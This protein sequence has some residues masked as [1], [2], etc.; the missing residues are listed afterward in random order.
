[1]KKAKKATKKET[2]GLRLDLGCGQGCRAGY[3]GVDI[4]KLPGVKYVVD[5]TKFPWPWKDGSVAEIYAQQF[6]EH[7]PAKL[8]YKFMDEA[9]RVLGVGGKAAFI[10]PY[11]ASMRAIQDVSHEWPPVCEAFYAY[12]NEAWRIIN[13]LTHYDVSCNFDAAGIHG[14]SPEFQSK[15]QETIAFSVQHYI[16]IAN[17]LFITLTKIPRL[18]KEAIKNLEQQRAETLKKQAEA[19]GGVK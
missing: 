9:W 5:L 6:L 15:S 11:W 4:V 18:E 10:T 3:D 16:N 7:I 19:Q 17:D 12:L 14:L 2:A 1:M 8:R 13:G